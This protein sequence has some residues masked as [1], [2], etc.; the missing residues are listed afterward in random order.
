MKPV[1]INFLSYLSLS[2]PDRFVII[3]AR[4][5]K[6]ARRLDILGMSRAA[7]LG[8]PPPP[9]TASDSTVDNQA[10]ENV[11]T[12]P[13]PFS[14]SATPG[15]YSLF[16]RRQDVQSISNHRDVTSFFSHHQSE[17]LQNPMIVRASAVENDYQELPFIA[18][19]RT[20]ENVRS[21]EALGD[22]GADG[23]S[24]DGGDGRSDGEEEVGER[25]EETHI[26]ERNGEELL[27]A[28]DTSQGR[29]SVNSCRSDT[30]EQ[31]L[32]FTR[33]RLLVP[34]SNDARLSS[35]SGFTDGA[36]LDD[37]GSGETGDLE[38]P[39]YHQ[40]SESVTS[41][42][43]CTEDSQN[44]YVNVSFIPDL[45]RET[46]DLEK[47]SG[48]GITVLQSFQRTTDNDEKISSCPE[49]VRRELASKRIVQAARREPSERNGYCYGEQ[50]LAL[51]K[52][53][54]DDGNDCDKEVGIDGYINGKCNEDIYNENDD[55][56]GNKDG[57]EESHSQQYQHP[58][59]KHRFQNYHDQHRL[60]QP[61]S[62][63]MST[64][65]FEHPSLETRGSCKSHNDGYE[66]PQSLI[67]PKP[68]LQKDAA[69]AA[70]NMS[71]SPEENT[72]AFDNNG[73]NTHCKEILKEYDHLVIE[74]IR[75]EDVV[76]QVLD[77]GDI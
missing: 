16:P 23:F 68:R 33:D 41:P 25:N 24:V 65:V 77:I 76:Y 27:A 72:P 64:A 21:F 15:P 53:Q 30:I 31:S 2:F 63:K 36:D 54:D 45:S 60:P 8:D 70:S 13:F 20:N 73:I 50:T 38:Y 18:L 3:P 47:N 34:V 74:D 51:N 58:Q 69:T 22:G 42:I 48:I 61:P 39:V 57:Y 62:G 49:S 4:Q 17:N 59:E 37:N 14:A 56:V 26:L 12:S 29:L 71:K 1:S 11:Y 52:E 35:D 19:W 66:I 75:T 67:R 9:Y 6:S 40:L 7:G 55:D 46:M 43:S 44:P 32:G 10:V 5:K 28:E